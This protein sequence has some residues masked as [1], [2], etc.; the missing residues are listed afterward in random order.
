MWQRSCSR[1]HRVAQSDV[2]AVPVLIVSWII[3]RL[4]LTMFCDGLWRPLSCSSCY[5]CNRIPDI[6]IM[7]KRVGCKRQRREL[8]SQE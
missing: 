5:A 3:L 4:G 1:G 6:D 8:R 7:V 2:L